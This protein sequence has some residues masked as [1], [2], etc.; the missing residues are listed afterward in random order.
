[1][2]R[3]PRDAEMRRRA[4]VPRGVAAAATPAGTGEPR[5]GR[6]RGWR[7]TDD[8]GLR[9]PARAT[10]DRCGTRC[11]RCRAPRRPSADVARSI[12]RGSR[13]VGSPPW[14]STR[15][16]AGVRAGDRR[17]VARAICSWRT[18][19][20]ELAH[21]VGGHLRRHGTRRDDRTHGRAGRREVDARHRARAAGSSRGP[22]RGGARGRSH[23]A[24]HGRR[25]P[26]RPG[27]HAGARHRPGRVHPIDGHARPPRRH[28]PGGARGGAHPR[29]SRLRPDHRGDRRRRSG[30]GRRGG[31]HRHRRRGARAG[32]RRRR[33][34]GE[35]GHPRGG[36]RLRREQGGPRGSRRRRPRAAADAAP[37]CRPDWEPPVLGDRGPRGRG[38]RRACG[39][40]SEDHAR[41]SR[42][43]ARSTRSV[44]GASCARS[45]AWP[46][47]ASGAAAAAALEADAA[48]RR[49]SHRAS[50]RPVRGGRGPRPPRRT[51]ATLDRRC[52]A[53]DDHPRR[54][55]ASVPTRRVPASR[56]KPSTGPGIWSTGIRACSSVC[57][58]G[59][60]FT[61]GVY[62]SMYRGRRWTMRQFAGFGTA[63]R[64]E[65]AVPLPPGAGSDRALRRLRHA[66]ADGPGL[67]RPAHRG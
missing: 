11:R 7:S 39:P 28:G 65:R 50:H 23:L 30:G 58:A 46:P 38:H 55:D 57:P 9:A 31:R 45:N 35:G 48:A 5:D 3:R 52:E 67:G 4:G 37:R 27:A 21:D 17:A 47:S 16:V 18:A 32:A 25:A 60:P 51:G 15:L 36:R 54:Q 24:V 19:R 43:P 66:D 10:A 8:P 53:A 62:P 12:R 40:I 41:L 1:M 13:R 61:R 6:A 63:G 22:T 34:D 64:D 2:L 33:P 20:P 59:F 56:S 42:R 29:R 14:T 26:R 44:A 49:R